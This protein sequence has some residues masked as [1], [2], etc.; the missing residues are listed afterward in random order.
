MV[1]R[2]MTL[3]KRPKLVIECYP[4]PILHRQ[5]IA[6]KGNAQ[7]SRVSSRSSPSKWARMTQPTPWPW[8]PMSS[9]RRHVLLGCRSS[10]DHR[11]GI[12]GIPRILPNGILCRVMSFLIWG[13]RPIPR[14][15]ANCA[16]VEPAD[17]ASNP[18]PKCR[19]RSSEN[20]WEG[21]SSTPRAPA[22]IGATPPPPGR[23]A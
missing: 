9:I 3:V 14:E 17:L 18:A 10:P 5:V 1:H 16:L 23:R 8:I 15:P 21:S 22:S 13:A 6:N 19:W 12:V 2:W 7:L 11:R 4:M 20:H